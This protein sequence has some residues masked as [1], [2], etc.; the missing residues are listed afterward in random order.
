MF[1]WNFDQNTYTYTLFDE[2]V[3]EKISLHGYI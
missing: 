1:R 2:I 3:F